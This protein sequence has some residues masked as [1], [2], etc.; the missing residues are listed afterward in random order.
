VRL[1]IDTDHR[2]VGGERGDVRAED[3]DRA[4]AAV[5]EDERLA[6]AIGL[7]PDLDAVDVGVTGRA[8]VGSG[9]I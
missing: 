4:K 1:E 3:F 8:R 2:V 7:V 9:G 5:E 6:L